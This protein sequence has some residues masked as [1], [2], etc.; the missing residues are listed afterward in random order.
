ML[1]FVFPFSIWT[2]F[3]LTPLS[4]GRKTLSNAF[5]EP[6]FLGVAIAVVAAVN[7]SVGLRFRENHEITLGIMILCFTAV[8]I[9]FLVPALP[10]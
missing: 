8:G 10:E 4:S 5:V 3:V 2:I 9:F 6:V 1:A 7:A